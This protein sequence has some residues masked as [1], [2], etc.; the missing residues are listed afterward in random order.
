MSG[1]SNKG[2]GHP[3]SHLPWAVLFISEEK[4]PFPNSCC[5]VLYLGPDFVLCYTG[6]NPENIAGLT[7]IRPEQIRGIGLFSFPNYNTPKALL[8][9]APAPMAKTCHK[10]IPTFSD[11]F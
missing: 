2:L 5:A 9:R 11:G 10:W 8:A 1:G 6:V 4:T 7:K 3:I